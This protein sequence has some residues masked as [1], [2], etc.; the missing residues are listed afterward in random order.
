MSAPGM[1]YSAVTFSSS[2]PNT[3]FSLDF[4]GETPRSRRVRLSNAFAD[5]AAWALEHGFLTTAEWCA[6]AADL[7][8]LGCGL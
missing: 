6:E 5:R 8:A 2:V 7:I 3:F 4:V 1:V